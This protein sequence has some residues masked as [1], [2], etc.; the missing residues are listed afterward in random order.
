[1]IH[2]SSLCN[3]FSFFLHSKLHTQWWHWL[4]IFPVTVSSDDLNFT[5]HRMIRCDTFPILIGKYTISKGIEHGLENISWSNREFSELFLGN[6][7]DNKKY[8]GRCPSNFLSSGKF[9]GSKNI[10][11]K[12]NTDFSGNIGGDVVVE[13]HIIL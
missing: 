4:D 7:L 9:Y 2:N 1:M 10:I 6:G 3:N 13:L 11:L 8:I 5:E 12:K